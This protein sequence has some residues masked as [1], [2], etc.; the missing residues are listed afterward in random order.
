MTA[1]DVLPA[2]DDTE[3]LGQL[4][5]A[6]LAAGYTAERLEETLGTHELSARPVDVAVH[7]RRLDGDDAFTTLTRLFVLGLPVEAARL[8]SLAPLLES[9]GLVRRRGEEI[10]T[11]LRLVPHGDYFL[12]SDLQAEG[13]EAADFVP[14]IHAPSVTLAKLTVR[15]PVAATLDLGT[16]CAI[17]ALLASRHSERVVA[18]DVNARA[19]RFAAFNARLNGVEAIE[20]RRGDGFAPV[21]GSRF[22]LVVSNPPYVISPDASYS[23]RD[24]G[25]TG[26]ELCR[27]IVQ[28]LPAFLEEGGFGH[29]LVSWRHEGDWAAP[30]R[31]WVRDS[32]CD[33]WLLHFGTQDPLT[34][35]A[36]WLRPLGDVDQGEHEAGLDRWLRYLDD[37]DI[38]AIGYGAV[39]LRRR[40]GGPNWIREDDVALDRLEPAGEHTLRVVA[41]QDYLTALRDDFELL[42]GRFSLVP[43]HRLDQTLLTGKSGFTVESQTLRLDEGFCFR[44]AV[45]RYTAELLPH[46][47]GETPLGA[48]LDRASARIDLDPQERE[49]FVPAALPVVRRLL[50]LGFLDVRV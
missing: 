23:Y 40:T 16:G 4:R 11:T 46:F 49:R 8:A 36:S 22:D 33:A 39:T 34:H 1:T 48:V 3:A 24:S 7:R 26:D 35:A 47:D 27:R 13:A 10:V 29:V 30:L 20:T 18:T 12:A 6:L 19:L 17:Q 37:L 9:L 15:R 28:E 14:G 42:E 21:E 44:A 31:D 2:S 45:D 5:A 25:L 43:S 50:E 32:G 41:A 38:A